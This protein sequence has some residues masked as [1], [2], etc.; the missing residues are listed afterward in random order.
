MPY[1]WWSRDPIGIEETHCKSLIHPFTAHHSE[2]PNRLVINPYTGCQ[3]RC[4]Y[5]YGTYFFFPNFF[6]IIQVKINAPII[7]ER[8]VQQY[9]RTHE[10]FPAVYI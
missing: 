10:F 8:E 4:L 1:I 7:L 3:H 6:D 2:C 9:K 5:C